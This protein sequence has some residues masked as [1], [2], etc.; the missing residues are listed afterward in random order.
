MSWL[1]D[2]KRYFEEYERFAQERSARLFVVSSDSIPEDLTGIKSVCFGSKYTGS[3]VEE[4]VPELLRRAGDLERLSIT[5]CR[6]SWK[7]VSL[8]D[9]SKIS[10]LMFLLDGSV[11]YE[12]LSAPKLKYLRVHGIDQGPVAHRFHDPA[13]AQNGNAAFDT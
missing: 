4:V 10:E 12:K 5:A 6:L 8:L 13:G 7:Q 3:P 1:E 9:L 11:T 2:A